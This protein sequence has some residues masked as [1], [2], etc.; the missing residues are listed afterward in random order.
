MSDAVIP[1][2]ILYLVIL[3]LMT[4]WEDIKWERSRESYSELSFSIKIGVLIKNCK[5]IVIAQDAAGCAQEF[6][7]NAC[8]SPIPFLKE[9]CTLW[10]ICMNSDASHVAKTKVVARLVAELLSELVEG[11]FGRLSWKSC[12]SLKLV[13]YFSDYM[14]VSDVFLLHFCVQELEPPLVM[15]VIVIPRRL[16]T[17]CLSVCS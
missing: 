2:L 13:E 17:N 14:L 15:S 7:A 11:F 1:V 5:L 12:V 16:P 4:L 10:N 8:E 6:H 9:Q 3:L